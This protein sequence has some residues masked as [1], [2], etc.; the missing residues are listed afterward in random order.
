MTI[1]KTTHFN[2]DKPDKGTTN[3]NL[4]LNE[5]FDKLDT[6]L[7]GQYSRLNTLIIT[8]IDGE[9]SAQELIDARDGSATLGERLDDIDETITNVQTNAVRSD[10]ADSKT[11]DLTMVNDSGIIFGN[12]KFSFNAGLGT[13]DITTI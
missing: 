12:I 4:N 2:L 8:P 10:I 6:E 9:G 13:V 7:Y 11:G 1:E 5:N 3:W